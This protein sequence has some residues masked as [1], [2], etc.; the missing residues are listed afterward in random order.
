MKMEMKAVTVYAFS[1]ENFNRP[2]E[3]INTLMELAEEKFLVF[4]QNR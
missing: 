4:F 3:E 2:K 1:I